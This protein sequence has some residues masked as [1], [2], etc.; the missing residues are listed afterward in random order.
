[1]RPLHAELMAIKEKLARADANRSRFD[2]SLSSIPPELQEQLEQRLQQYLGPKV[3]DEARQQSARVLSATE[4][5][6]DKRTIEVREEFQQLDGGI[7]KLDESVRSLEAGLDQRLSQMAGDTVRNTRNEIESVAD[8]M[9]KQLTARS[10]QTIGDQM[11]EAA[12]NMR[13]FHQGI[14]ASGSD[15][16]KTKAAEALQDFEHSRD[17]LAPLSIEASRQRLAS[18]TNTTATN[19]DG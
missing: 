10:V 4:A 12:G 19:S 2:V 7:R 15:A 16:L 14:I 8:S 3:L 9:L 18:R 13:I 11:E 17:E 1:V 6:I 5:V